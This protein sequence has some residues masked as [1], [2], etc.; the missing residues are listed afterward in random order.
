MPVE[1]QLPRPKHIFSPAAAGGSSST[2]AQLQQYDVVYFQILDV[3]PNTD[4]P[5][6]VVPDETE[7]VLKGGSARVLLP[8]GFKGYA[9]AAAVCG[10][11]STDLQ[12]QQ[13]LPAV[14]LLGAHASAA[15]FDRVGFCGVPGILTDTWRHVSHVIAPLLH[16]A[17]QVRK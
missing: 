7:L 13:L 9:A 3:L 6:A 17:S 14:P 8:V 11:S 10:S 1:V 12:Q 2:A 5:L 4:Q 15:H 16:P